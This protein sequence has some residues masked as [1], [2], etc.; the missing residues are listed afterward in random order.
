MQKIRLS[1]DTMRVYEFVVRF[2][3]AHGGMSPTQQDIA[4]ACFMSRSSV[5]KHLTFLHASGYI[6][7]LPGAKRAIWLPPDEPDED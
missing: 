6:G 2:I 5:Q 1:P 4:A 3:Q 7:W